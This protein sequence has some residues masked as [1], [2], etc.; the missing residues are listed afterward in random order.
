[1]GVELNVSFDTGRDVS[2]SSTDYSI[3][4]GLLADRHD[5]IFKLRAKVFSEELNW[6]PS[7]SRE[8]DPYDQ[9]ASHVSVYSGQQLQ[10]VLRILGC[11][12]PWMIQKEFQN[13]AALDI[14]RRIGAASCEVTRLAVRKSQRKHRFHNGSLVSDLLYQGLFAYCVLNDIRYVYMV[15]STSV[16]RALRFSGLPCKQIT[17]PVQMSDGVIA[18]SACLDWDEFVEVNLRSRP[19]LAAAYMDTLKQAQLGHQE[20]DSVLTN[21]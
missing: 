21:S 3:Y 19:E 9:Y 4:C 5:D 17:E 11:D 6:V 20:L 1:M 16:L 15:V 10:G 13:L 14:Y 8:K 18:V 12:L 2:I 7:T